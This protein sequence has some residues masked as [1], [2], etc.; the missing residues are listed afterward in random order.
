MPAPPRITV[1]LSLVT[2]QAK[3]SMGLK[4]CGWC[5][6]CPRLLWPKIGARYSGLGQIVVE[7]VAFISPGQPIIQAELGLHTPGILPEEVEGV[8]VVGV[9][10][11]IG[12]RLVDIAA[13]HLESSHW[14]LQ[15]V[16][17]CGERGGN[18]NAIRRQPVCTKVRVEVLYVRRREQ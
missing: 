11:V 16:A 15:D 4:L 17:D 7:R 9:A 2:F 6:S 3:P 13:A 8:V 1:L 18:I 5:S 12:R 10:M 14:K